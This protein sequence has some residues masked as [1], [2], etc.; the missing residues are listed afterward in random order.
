VSD[1]QVVIFTPKQQADADAERIYEA[2]PKKVAKP[3]ALRAIKRALKDNTTEFLL[4]RTRLFTTTYNGD[5]KYIPY[6]ASWFNN[7]R[8]NDDPTTWRK[9]A[10]S[11][12]GGFVPPRKFESS[13]YNQEV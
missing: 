6:P 8:F 11:S 1:Q 7:H 10:S 5:P 4:E 13:N 2:Y 3:A 9:T 12:N